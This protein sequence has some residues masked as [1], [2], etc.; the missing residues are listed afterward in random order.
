MKKSPVLIELESR[1]QKELLFLDGAMGTVIQTYKLQEKDFK[2]GPFAD[3]AKDLRGNN[4]LLT[5]TRPEVISEIHWKYL[6]AGADIIETNTFNATTVSQAD[7]GL[8]KFVHLLNFEAAKL[9]KNTARKFMEKY[10]QRKVYVAGALGPTVKTSSLSPDVNNPGFRAITFEELRACYYQQTKALLEGGVDLLLPETCIDTL[11]LKACLFA[12]SQ[13]E[14]ERQEK[15]PLMISMTI[16]DASGRTLSGQTVEAFWNSIRHARPLSVGINCALGAKE[17]GPF[18]RDLAGVADCFI[19]CYPNAGLPNPLSLT[20][21]D[22]TPES[23]AHQLKLFAEEGIV[24]IVGG[25]CGTTPPHIQAITNALRT[26]TPRKYS[27]IEPRLRLSGLEPLNLTASGPRSFVMIGERTNVTGSPKFSKLIKDDKYDEALTVAR[28]QVENGANII[29]INFDEG[30]IDGKKA[31]RRFLNLLGSEPDISRIPFMIDSSKWEILEAG[32]QCLQGKAIVNSISL[33]EGEKE[34]LRQARLARL[35]GAAVVVM[36]FD[37]KGQAATKDDKVR[38]CSRAYKLLTEQVDFDPSDIIFDPNVLTEATGMEEHNSFGLDYLQGVEEIKRV[39]PGV[40]TSGGIS[41]FSFSFRGNNPVREAMHAVFLY[42]AIQRGLDMGIVNAGMLEVYEEIDPC[43]RELVE[44]VVLNKSPEA[45]EQLL[46]FAEALKESNKENA[47]KSSAGEPVVPAE[48]LWRH[49]TLQ[50]RMTH[51]LVKGVDT[52]IEK[53]TEEARQALQLPLKVIE[54]PLMDGMKV[55]GQ[56]FG[57]GKMFLPQVVKSAPG[58]EKSCGLPGTLH[59]RRKKE[60]SHAD[61]GPR[62]A[63]DSQR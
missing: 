37:E 12:I 52:F 10:P 20:G 4:D 62:F 16:T 31:M 39:C 38:I 60:K 40:F 30:M 55:V 58:D 44:A 49:G 8:E 21:Y 29:D 25:C 34:F 3:A 6:E 48:A 54:G 2:A 50:E 28:Q 18:L 35:Y 11:N 17:M 59:G 51:A 33:K 24:N 57:E 9:A 27:A 42:H 1:L 45:S 7:Y 53:D 22:E 36:A 61:P 15:L 63:S 41:N 14:E 43:L 23:L 26:F 13:I 32:L 46:D 19:S 47:A 56:L 5:I